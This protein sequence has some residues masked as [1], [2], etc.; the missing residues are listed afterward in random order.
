MKNDAE[1]ARWFYIFRVVAFSG[2]HGTG[3]KPLWP[4]PVPHV[5]AAARDG[6][7]AAGVLRMTSTRGY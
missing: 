7:R 4:K 6:R 1:I 3:L 5:F 2:H